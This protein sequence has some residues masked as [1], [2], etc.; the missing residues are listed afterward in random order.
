MF[1]LQDP[2]SSFEVNRSSNMPSAQRGETT[3]E[4]CNNMQLNITNVSVTYPLVTL[5]PEI[6]YINL[7]RAAIPTFLGVTVYHNRARGQ[8]SRCGLAIQVAGL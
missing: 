1:L 5:F 8:K 3:E 2:H 4:R 7:R 6:S